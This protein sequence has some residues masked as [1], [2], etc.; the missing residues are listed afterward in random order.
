MPAGRVIAVVL[1]ALASLGAAGCYADAPIYASCSADIGCESSADACF[2]VLVTRTDG[3][4]GDASLCTRPCSRHDECPNGGLCLQLVG[5]AASRLLCYQTCD[6]S[7]DCY[8]PLVCTPTTGA[9]G[10]PQVCL[11]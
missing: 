4:T 11:P 9:P 1:G 7:S 8:S 2:R 5:D 3:T 6:T 10:D